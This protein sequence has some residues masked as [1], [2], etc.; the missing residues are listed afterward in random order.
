MPLDG[1]Q[2]ELDADFEILEA[3]GRIMDGLTEKCVRSGVCDKTIRRWLA[4]HRD[5]PDD[6]HEQVAL[7]ALAND[8]ELF[9]PSMSGK[10]AVD[11]L[12]DSRRPETNLERAAFAALRAARLHL[13]RIVERDGSDLVVMQDLATQDSLML[14]DSR[15]SP[16]AAGSATAMRL[17]PLA[18]GSHVLISPLFAMDEDTLADALTFV[19]PGKSLG[20]GHRCATN[21]YRD[22]ARRDYRPMPTFASPLGGTVLFD[23]EQDEIELTEMQRLGVRWLLADGGDDQGEVAA[24]IRRAASRDNLV[25]ACGWFANAASDRRENMMQAFAHIAEIHM[26]TLCLRA[27]TGMS[28]SAE[29][30]DKAQSQIAGHVKAGRMHAAATD[31]FARLRLR[32]SVDKP[33]DQGDAG[34][35]DRAELDRVIQR[36]IALRAKTIDRGCTEQEAMAAAAKVAQLLD[37]YDLSLDEL[38]VRK[39]ECAGATI[40]TG[41]RRRAPIDACVQPVADFC[42]CTAWS[43]EAPGGELRVVFFGLK[44]DVEAARFLHDMIEAA[45]ETESAAFRRSKIYQ[46]LYGGERRTALNSFQIGLAGGINRKLNTLKNARGAGGVA[47]SGFDLVAVKHA[48]VDDEVDKLGLSF[49][50]K[51]TSSRRY[52]DSEAYDAGKAAGALFEPHGSLAR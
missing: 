31:L 34:A 44:A 51:T 6:R 11:R 19:R 50:T 13:V 30:L 7:M 42:D 17:C 39:S 52:V 18:S 25:D 14:L 8:L 16:L 21:L 2:T 23:D 26:E 22:I 38:A 35:T 47:S 1:T 29:M 32:W 45:F 4:G 5:S 37:R 48:V 20:H 40:E 41:R 12:L 46:D 10:T 9:T 49:R 43:E 27:Q 15:I 28:G 36:I 33:R 3:I 24:D